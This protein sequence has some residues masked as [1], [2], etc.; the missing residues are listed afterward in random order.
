[1][2][3]LVRFGLVSPETHWPLWHR[4]R[5]VQMGQRNQSPTIDRR[6]FELR[7]VQLLCDNAMAGSKLNLTFG[8]S[9]QRLAF[10]YE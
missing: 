8:F 10:L 5:C 2:L 9:R 4:G 1:M 7:V 6:P 3:M